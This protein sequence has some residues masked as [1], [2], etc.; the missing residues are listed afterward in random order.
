MNKK[1][2]KIGN[3]KENNRTLVVNCEKKCMP[4]CVDNRVIAGYCDNELPVIDINEIEQLARKIAHERFTL[5]SDV[6][7]FVADK[8]RRVI[9]TKYISQ[10]RGISK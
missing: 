6:L 7:P 4:K 1:F 9:S 3:D 5:I 10:E 8:G 2:C